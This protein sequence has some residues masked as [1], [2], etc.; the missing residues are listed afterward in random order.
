MLIGKNMKFVGVVGDLVLY[1]QMSDAILDEGI[2]SV[3][4]FKTLVPA[5][6]LAELEK[7]LKDNEDLRTFRHN[8]TLYK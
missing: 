5:K 7:R 2:A 6:K 8:L 1:D 4:R 3:Y